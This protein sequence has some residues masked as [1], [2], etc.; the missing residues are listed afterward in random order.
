[1]VVQ[2]QTELTSTEDAPSEKHERMENELVYLSM[3]LIELNTY[4]IYQ[5]SPER[6]A[7]LEAFWALMN[8][9]GLNM[10][11]VRKRLDAYT[12]A[13]RTESKDQTWQNIGRTFAWH[14]LAQDD[15]NIAALGAKM[16]RDISEELQRLLKTASVEL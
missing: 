4:L 7:V 9:S 13:A 6:T 3:F 1:M 5:D 16:A 8:D 15:F 10:D 2:I 12:D 11:V 14:C